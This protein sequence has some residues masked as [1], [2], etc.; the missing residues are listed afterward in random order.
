MNKDLFIVILL[1]LFIVNLIPLFVLAWKDRH[2]EYHGKVTITQWLAVLAWCGAG[3]GTL[4]G[5]LLF[6]KQRTKKRFRNAVIGTSVYAALVLAAGVFLLKKDVPSE[7]ETASVSVTQTAKETLPTE[8]ETRPTEIASAAE[9]SSEEASSE[10]E[11]KKP[12]EASRITLVAIGDMLMH[13]G[14]SAYAMMPDGSIDYKFIF[15]PIQE[16]V[17]NADIAIVNNEVP[18]GGNEYG[19]KN[20]PLFNVYSELGDEEVRAGFDVILCAT[21][22]VMDMNVAGLERTMAF[23]KK[24][25]QMTILGVHESQ[26]A[27][28]TLQF[29]ERNGVKIAMYNCTYGINSYGVPADRPY[30]VDLMTQDR[31]S[32]IRKMLEK[33][34]R[35]ADF[36]IVFPHWGSEYHLKETSDQHYWASFFTECGADLI[37]GTHPHVLEPVKTVT[38]SN[39]NTSLCYYSLGNY[40]SLQDETISV[41]GGM[42]KVTLFADADSVSVE[43]Y[44]TQYLVTHY[45]KDINYPYVLKLEDYTEELASQHGIPVVGLPGDNLNVYYPFSLATLHRVIDE[46]EGRIPDAR[47]YPTPAPEPE[48]TTEEVTEEVTEESEAVSESEEETPSEEE[49]PA[50]TEEEPPATSEAEEDTSSEAT[51]PLPP[52][53]EEPETT[54]EEAEPT[55]PDSEAPDTE[56]SD[57]P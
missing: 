30:L 33:A 50:T 39:G 36:T 19:L 21:N 24:Y 46:V 32:T 51:E 6:P 41:L 40:I 37:I 5:F 12:R 11:T 13:P 54:S 4:I 28:D 55:I 14:V 45:G 1:L 15:K 56:G 57:N 3:L 23:W 27:Q 29:V 10:E 44:D 9:S 2:S 34:E 25:P 47:V 42:A 8:E 48:P 26:E 35:E 17:K 43:S 31:M 52:S 38:A 22:H 16:E 20:Y 7:P 53:S 18:F 49:P